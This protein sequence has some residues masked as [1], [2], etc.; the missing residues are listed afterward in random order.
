MK[1][2]QKQLTRH[3]NCRF[4]QSRMHSWQKFPL[5]YCFM[6]TLH[7]PLFIHQISL[8]SGSYWPNEKKKN[9][10]WSLTKIIKFLPVERYICISSYL[11][12]IT[13][14]YV[15]ILRSEERRDPK[16]RVYF[17]TSFWKL[18]W[19]NRWFQ[20]QPL[21][22]ELSLVISSQMRFL[23]STLKGKTSKANPT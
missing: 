22:M 11:K 3:G 6:L 19:Q 1:I 20:R 14:S 5:R 16:K 18:S 23:C 12:F 7:G 15:T 21:E 9:H 8:L 13:F 2:V 4:P 17:C 10:G